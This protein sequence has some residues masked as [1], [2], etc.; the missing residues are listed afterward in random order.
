MGDQPG[1]AVR[2]V[3]APYDSYVNADTNQLCCA[4]G[5]EQ[6]HA[7]IGGNGASHA[8]LT[9][10]AGPAFNADGIHTAGTMFLDEDCHATSATADGTAGALLTGAVVA[11]L[12]RLDPQQTI[13][14]I[15]AGGPTGDPRWTPARE[16]LCAIRTARSPQHCPLRS[17]AGSPDMSVGTRIPRR[18][19]S[20]TYP[21]ARQSSTT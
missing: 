3:W 12:R 5:L 19:N 17:W 4:Q 1:A 2:S 8:V 16:H 11:E 21:T 6:A 15:V 18:P 14:F 10:S 13:E 20:S 7:R 9:N